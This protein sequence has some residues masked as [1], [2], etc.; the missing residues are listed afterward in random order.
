MEKLEK[1]KEIVKREMEGLDPS[2][3]FLHVMRVYNLCLLIAKSEKDVD[4]EVL[5]AAALLHDIARIR[6][7]EDKSGK[8]NYEILGAEMAEKILR[9]MNYSDYQI[10]KIKHC[11]MTHRFRTSNRPQTAEAKILSDADKIDAIG[12]TG[13]ARTFV[14]AGL[15]KQKIY[16]DVNIEEYA[17]ENL[18]D[19]KYD[20]KIKDVSKHSPIIEFNVKLKRIPEKLL[21]KRG[22]EI[23]SERIEFM[24]KFFEMIEDEMKGEK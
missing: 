7:I 9:G 17:K 13:I 2:H 15:Y 5:K 22:K 23:G 18:I 3:D 24:E 14:S 6:E 1:I 10:E 11:I 16:S 4:M 19:G 12:A 20:G 8:I 21:T